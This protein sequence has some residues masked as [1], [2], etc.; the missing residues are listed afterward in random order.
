MKFYRL[1]TFVLVL[2]VL[3]IAA[4]CTPRASYPPPDP[5]PPTTGQSGDESTTPPPAYPGQP[6]EQPGHQPDQADYP[7]VNKPL[8]PRTAAEVSGPAV[9]ALISR[10]EQRGQS[11]DLDSAAASLERALDLEP[12]N[13]FVYQKLA[14]TRLQQGQPEQAEALARKANSLAGENPFIKAENWRIVAEARVSLGDNVGASSASSR[15]DY[16]QYQS[17]NLGQQRSNR[18]R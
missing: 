1:L 6:S 9:V 15:A 13:P 18:Q 8:P 17:Q 5:Y 3:L 14:A 7:P 10:A 2:P 16:Y 4:A 11:G 12:R